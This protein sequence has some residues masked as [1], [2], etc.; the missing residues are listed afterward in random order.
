[1]LRAIILVAGLLIIS[2]ATSGQETVHNASIKGLNRVEL[3]VHG[4]GV[5]EALLRAISERE[6]IKNGINVMAD[7]VRS[8]SGIPILTLDVVLACS[9][10]TCGYSTHLKLDESVKLVR[11]PSKV[12]KATVWS[13]GYH[14][15]ISKRELTSL[16]S[17]VSVDVYTL[18]NLFAAEET[19]KVSY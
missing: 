16:P 19:G 13:N 1:M 17:L 18:I 15:A 8:E 2:H 3:K 11:D 9:N 10:N 12:V 7:S 14:N 6:L 5:D 4:S